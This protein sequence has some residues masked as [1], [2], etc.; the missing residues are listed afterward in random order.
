MRCCGLAS[1][2]IKAK[3]DLNEI[4]HIIQNRAHTHSSTRSPFA[5]ATFVVASQ[6]AADD[7]AV[8]LQAMMRIPRA[9]VAF[10]AFSPAR[11]SSQPA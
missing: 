2:E 7:D 9:V 3:E 10:L 8:V 11:L 4:P 1:V 6:S 5:A